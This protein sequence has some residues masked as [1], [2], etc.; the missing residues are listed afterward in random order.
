MKILYKVL[1]AACL[2]STITNIK[3]QELK[4]IQTPLSWT[5]ERDSLSI[6]YLSKRHG[7]EQNNAFITPRMVVVH[8]TANHSYDA[9]WNT[10]KEARLK[11][12]P[13]LIQSSALNVSSQYVIERDG[14]IYQLL[15]DTLFARHTIGLNY[16]AIGIENIGSS[17]APLT[18]EQLEA[19]TALINQLAR[20]YPIQQVIGHHEY[21]KFR[22]TV[23]WKETDPNYFTQKNDPGKKFMRKLRRNLKDLQL[24]NLPDTDS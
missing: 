9:T 18:K 4:I 11:G 14:T 2:T 15:P 5:A 13:E 22:H 7:I 12:R 1:V 20:K 17:N 8:W 16:C 3:A 10:F 21:L 6:E 23:W 24:D 19:N